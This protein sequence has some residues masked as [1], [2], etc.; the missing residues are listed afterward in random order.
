[1]TFMLTVF[2][3]GFT[4]DM[5]LIFPTTIITFETQF[6][7]V[8]RSRTDFLSI[9]FFEVFDRQCII[10][11]LGKEKRKKRFMKGRRWLRKVVI[12]RLKEGLKGLEEERNIGF[13]FHLKI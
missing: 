8:Y 11:F 1:M 13:D 12:M 4:I 7:L 9:I 5:K 10:G 6:A 2:E 3:T